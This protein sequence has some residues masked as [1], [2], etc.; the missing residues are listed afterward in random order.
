MPISHLARP[1]R[2]KA[3]SFAAHLKANNVHRRLYATLVV[4]ADKRYLQTWSR[5]GRALRD[6]LYGHRSGDQ[7]QLARD[8]AQPK[9]AKSAPS[10]GPT[11]TPSNSDPDRTTTPEEIQDPDFMAK[12]TH[13]LADENAPSFQRMLV[14]SAAWPNIEHPTNDIMQQQQFMDWSTLPSRSRP[15]KA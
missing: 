2:T 7:K 1:I 14:T 11:A 9:Y 3:L 10:P 6:G 15:S 12:S 4:P 8:A 13:E 5:N